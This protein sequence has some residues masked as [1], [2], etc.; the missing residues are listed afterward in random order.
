MG[1]G[2]STKYENT[3]FYTRDEEDLFV[4]ERT[5]R[6]TGDDT[7]TIEYNNDEKVMRYC[8][9]MV[10]REPDATSSYTDNALKASQ[11]FEL[12]EQGFF[13]KR[14]QQDVWTIDSED[15]MSSA[16]DFYSKISD[17]GATEYLPNR[18]GIQ[19][20][21]C[22]GTKTFFRPYPKSEGCP[23]VEIRF[24]MENVMRKIHFIKR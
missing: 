7:H 5:E 19:T 18:H 9:E 23:A 17:G 4:S 16:M 21:L 15:P 10:S 22:D 20:E 2:I 13:G 8:D 3:Y 14:S 11:N 24:S 12:N 6:Y 1:S